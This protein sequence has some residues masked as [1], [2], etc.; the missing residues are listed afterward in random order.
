MRH[1]RCWRACTATLV[2]GMCI[3]AFGQT[4]G[5]A[6]EAQWHVSL[7]GFTHHAR[8][9]LAPGQQWQ[10]V[11][12]G[13]GLQR[14][15]NGMP[16][17][18]VGADSSWKSRVLFGTMEDSRGFLGSYGGISIMR[19][20]AH[21]GT[22]RLEA[23]LSAVTYYRSSSWNGNMHFVPAILPTLSL[24]GYRTGLG[25]DLS[26]VP[27]VTA[28]NTGSVSTLLLQFTYRP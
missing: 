14:R 21:V 1:H 7:G 10:D 26:W 22:L 8:Q 17:P 24:V 27:P 4:S 23:G 19:E 11:H 15:L 16:W 5:V 9:T 3:P 20:I 6:T 2:A 18:T 28:K 12:P 25:L 13:I